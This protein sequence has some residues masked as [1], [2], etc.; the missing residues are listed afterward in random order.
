M[1]QISIICKKKSF[2]V[3]YE[4]LKKG[5]YCDEKDTNRFNSFNIRNVALFC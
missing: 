5:G 3:Q 4:A 1:P 2:G